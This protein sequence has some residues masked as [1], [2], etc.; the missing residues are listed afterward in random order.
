VKI[1]GYDVDQLIQ[2]LQRL[3]KISH[4]SIDFEDYSY[5]PETNFTCLAKCLQGRHQSLDTLSLTLG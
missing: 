1:T 3:N 2:K 5:I 4:L